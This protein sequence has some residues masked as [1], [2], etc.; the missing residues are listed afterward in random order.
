ML[1]G[2]QALLRGF[3]LVGERASIHDTHV[4]NTVHPLSPRM[5]DQQAPLL[6]P[7]SR[8]RYLL[9]LPCFFAFSLPP[10]YGATYEYFVVIVHVR[11]GEGLS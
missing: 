1:G 10:P 9:S 7:L 11:R 3:G 4:V 5:P 6:L 8:Q 2:L